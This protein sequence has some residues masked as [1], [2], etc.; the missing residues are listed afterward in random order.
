LIDQNEDDEKTRIRNLN[1]S[2][3]ASGQGGRIVST[4]GIQQLSSVDQAAVFEKIRVFDACTQ[5]NDPHGEHEFG[6][7][8]YGGEKILF[9]IGYYDQR[10]E[11]HNEN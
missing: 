10:L 1:D 2:F 5:A 11:D 7:I 4:Q 8:E 6:S 9:R 3:R